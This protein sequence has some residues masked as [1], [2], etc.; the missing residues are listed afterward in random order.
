VDVFRA[1]VTFLG[2]YRFLRKS[3]QQI[4]SICNWKGLLL[5]EYCCP[6]CSGTVVTWDRRLKKAVCARDGTPVS[7]FRLPVKG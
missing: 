6:E 7:E 3:Y 5:V 2:A 1:F 4:T